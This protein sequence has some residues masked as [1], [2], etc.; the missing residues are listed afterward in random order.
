MTKTL[1]VLVERKLDF[2]EDK[3]VAASEDRQALIERARER[4]LHIDPVKL[5]RSS[6]TKIDEFTQARIEQIEV[7]EPQPRPVATIPRTEQ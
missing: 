6:E 1:N 2:T 4:H 3:I 5:D 7:I